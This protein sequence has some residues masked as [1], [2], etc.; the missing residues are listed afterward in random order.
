MADVLQEWSQPVT[1]IGELGQDDVGHR[2][3]VSGVVSETAS[4]AAGFKFVISDST[5]D[6]AA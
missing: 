1:P 5:G 3:T 4:F 6:E 2:V